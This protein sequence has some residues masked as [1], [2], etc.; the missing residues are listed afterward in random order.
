MDD[1]HQHYMNGIFSKEGTWK[2]LGGM[3]RDHTD[4]IWERVPDKV[5]ELD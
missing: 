4:V 5:A 2:E 1:F 3:I